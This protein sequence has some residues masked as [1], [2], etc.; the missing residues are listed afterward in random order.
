MIFDYIDNIEQYRHVSKNMGK[1]VD[2]VKEHDLSRYE[3]GHYVIDEDVYFDVKKYQTRSPEE[4]GWETHRKYI[5]IQ[6]ILNGIELIGIMPATMMC[7]K[8]PYNEIK[9]K[10]T[11]K[12]VEK[13]SIMRL[14]DGMFVILFPQ[15]AHQPKMWDENITDN[16]KV[17][18]KVKI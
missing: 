11:Y 1:F 16:K 17:V 13:R 14:T 3:A 4:S 6:Y 12:Q 2:Y 18:V 7:I 8:E 9:D 15:D 10:Q 5:D